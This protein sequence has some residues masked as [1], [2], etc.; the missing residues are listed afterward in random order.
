MAFILGLH[1]YSSKWWININLTCQLVATDEE[2]QEYVPN[3]D[4]EEVEQLE[5]MDGKHWLS[6]ST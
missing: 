5:A 1:A 4:V 6:K 2:D 3:D